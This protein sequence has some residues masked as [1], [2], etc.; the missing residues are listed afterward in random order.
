MSLVMEVSDYIT[1]IDNGIKIGEGTP[2]V[3][4]TDPI[5]R[6]AYLGE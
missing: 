4:S 6:K 5:V 3:V 1:V 2:S